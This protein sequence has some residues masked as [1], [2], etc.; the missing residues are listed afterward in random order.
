MTPRSWKP[1]SDTYR[2][3]SDFSGTGVGVSLDAEFKFHPRFSI[4]SGLAIGLLTG[5]ISTQSETNTFFY[6]DT[7]AGVILTPEELFFI[8]ENG[9]EQQIQ[10]LAQVGS[11]LPRTRRPRSTV[12]KRT[13][14]TSASRP[15]CG[16]G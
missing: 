2:A 8:L 5:K 11:R 15:R 1:R 12:P 9:S 14:P 6:V 7:L 3:Q 16:A 10:A 13:K 4:V